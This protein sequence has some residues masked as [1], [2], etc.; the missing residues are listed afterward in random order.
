MLSG[1]HAAIERWR[2]D[3]RLALT[4]A[5]RPELLARARQAGAL[6]RQDEA[7]L[8]QLPDTTSSH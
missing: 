5:R 8:S 2:R 6:T 7:F 1:D 4:Q 3:Q